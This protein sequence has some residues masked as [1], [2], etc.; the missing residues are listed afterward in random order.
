[1]N[2]YKVHEQQ[3]AECS[4]SRP[5]TLNLSHLSKGMYVIK[6]ETDLGVYETKLQLE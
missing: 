2:G 1:M 5:L 3:F 4:F 6:F